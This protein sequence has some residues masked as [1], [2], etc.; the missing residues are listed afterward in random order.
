[1]RK[2]ATIK[3]RRLLQ[4]AACIAASALSASA[5]LVLNPGDAWTNSFDE[6]PFVGEYKIFPGDLREAIFSFT[7]APGT[8]ESGSELYFELFEGG[9]TGAPRESGTVTTEPSQPVTIHSPFTWQDL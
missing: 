5:Q 7:I 1:M 3:A 6:L 2:A 4:V 9:P 8:F